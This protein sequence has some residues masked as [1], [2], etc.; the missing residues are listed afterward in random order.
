MKQVCV[1]EILLNLSRHLDALRIFPLFCYPTL[2]HSSSPFLLWP[3]TPMLSVLIHRSNW[4]LA[5]VFSIHIWSTIQSVIWS[6]GSDTYII[7]NK[8]MYRWVWPYKFI[9]NQFNPNHLMYRQYK[10]KLYSIQLKEQIRP[11]N[12]QR[13]VPHIL[14][15]KCQLN[16][17]KSNLITKG[18]LLSDRALVCIKPRNIFCFGQ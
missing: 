4:F 5:A 2:C 8:V 3:L 6:Q 17:E 14:Y 15:N 7:E 13:F 9:I 12:H 11:R 10:Q 16:W 1:W 18:I